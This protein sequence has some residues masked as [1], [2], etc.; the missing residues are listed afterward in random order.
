MATSSKQTDATFQEVL[1][2]IWH[3]LEERDW[4]T[5]PSRSLAISI[6]LE[7]NE[8]LEHYQWNDKAVGDKEAL[9]GE[10][11]D[12]LIYSFNFAERNGIDIPQAIEK[13]LAK[14]AKKYPASDFKG[15]YG[16]TR[17]KA[18]LDAKLNHKKEGL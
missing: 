8:L 13:K 7:A 1:D 11:A 4:D 16:A 2:K 12:I 17:E 3:H 15:K 5:L 18:W 9:A 14:T 6:S 10:L